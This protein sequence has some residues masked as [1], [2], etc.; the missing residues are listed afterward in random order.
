M[1]IYIQLLYVAQTSNALI[2][3]NLLLSLLAKAGCPPQ[4]CGGEG[5]VFYLFPFDN[6]DNV[7]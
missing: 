6:A 3:E 1:H 5:K 7:S 2:L 4:A